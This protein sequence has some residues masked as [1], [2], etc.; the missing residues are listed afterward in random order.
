MIRIAIATLGCKTNAYDSAAIID[1]F[2]TGSYQLVPFPEAADIYIIN[3]CTVTDRTDYKSRNLIRKALK[4]K[5]LN[6]AAKVLV[7]GCFA[8]RSHDQIQAMGAIDLIVDNQHKTDIAALLKAKKTGFMDIMDVVDFRYATVKNMVDRSRAFQKIQDGCDFYCSYCAVPY[9]RGHNRSARFEDVLAQAKLFMDGGYKE[10]VLGG[11]NLGL[12]DDHG[13][14]LT[15]VIDALQELD[16]LELIRLSSI[17]PQLFSQDLVDCIKRNS[18]ICPHFHIPLQ[19]GSDSVL[20]RMGRRY[21]AKLFTSLVE[22]IL[23]VIPDAAIGADVICGFPGETEAEF[24]ATYRLLESLPLAYLHVFSYSKRKGTSAA[25][26]TDQISTQ[27]KATRS[28]ALTSLSFD[29]KFDY[30]MSLVRNR[31]TLKG[32]VEEY[33][34]DFAIFL[35][36]HYIRGYTQSE[37]AVGEVVCIKAELPFFDG[38]QGC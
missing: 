34:D 6:P 28:S 11:V 38:V 19:S 23:A 32:V 30:M 25:R 16:G 13:R 4:Q 29:M 1:Q 3:T 17:E 24:A 12:Y 20:N 26:M 15:D 21:D 22:K 27:L 8:Q 14:G 7:T 2:E 35:S 9:A 18:K 33:I 37:I 36:D 5:A 31:I 10:I